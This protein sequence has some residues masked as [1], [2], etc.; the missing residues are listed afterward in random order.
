MRQALGRDGAKEIA[1]AS[2]AGAA[3]SSCS[4]DAA[5]RAVASIRNA[6]LSWAVTMVSTHTAAEVRA[7][8]ATTPQEFAPE[9]KP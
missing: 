3:S 4:Q 7:A 9:S 5:G 2:L 6:A 8:V 1:I